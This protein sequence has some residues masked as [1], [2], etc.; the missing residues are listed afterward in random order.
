[1]NCVKF[2]QS[3]KKFINNDMD[4]DELKDFLIHLNRCDDC[5]EEL[6][7]LF[8]VEKIVNDNDGNNYNYDSM[9][10][11]FIAEN[12]E[13]IYREMRFKY[14]STLFTFISLFT[15]IVTFVYFVFIMT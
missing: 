4:T 15:T 11:N 6:E 7:I 9:L 10:K 1:M 12:E 3:I 2:N 14:I 13:I 8:L 5:R